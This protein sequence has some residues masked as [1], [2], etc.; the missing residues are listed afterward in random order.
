MKFKLQMESEA[1]H[2]AVIDSIGHARN[3]CDDVEWSPEDGTRTE[4]DFLC[5]CVESAIKAG[6]R[7]INI[8]V[9]VGYTVPEEFAA[10]IAMLKNRLPNIDTPVIP[11]HLHNV[12]RLGAANSIDSMRAGTPQIATPSHGLRPATSHPPLA[13]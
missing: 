7:T 2:Q 13:Q 4:H 11:V 12:L 9:T 10:L 5:R 8:H 3:L 6:A 1:V